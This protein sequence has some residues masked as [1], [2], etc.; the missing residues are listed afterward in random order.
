MA[1]IQQ[2]TGLTVD[3]VLMV[4]A[5][6]IPKTSSG[7]HQRRKARTLFETGELKKREGEGKLRSAARV[8]ESQLAHLR[9]RI[10]GSRK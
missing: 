10:F 4:D 6:T 1:S 3:E 7:K 2:A 5:G 8:A 9:L